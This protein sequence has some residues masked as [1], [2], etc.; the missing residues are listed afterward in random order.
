MTL[1]RDSVYAGQYEA[2]QRDPIID[3]VNRASVANGRMSRWE[4]FN[5]GQT[6][7]AVCDN[8]GNA[9]YLTPKQAEIASMAN[10]MVDGEMLTM[11][12]MAKRLNVAPSTVSRALAKLMAW[13]ILVYMVGR[14]RFA[15]LVIVKYVRDGG[16]L[17]WKRKQAKERIRRWYESSQRRISR[18]A[19]NVAPYFHRGE[20]GVTEYL[21]TSTRYKGATLTLQRSWTVAEIEDSLR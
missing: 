15:G 19:F 1:T 16:F 12:E 10:G 11:R 3:R 6:L 17:D 20:E 5:R 8:E 18:L 14:G 4:R 9:R 2:R 13:G 21:S 7:V